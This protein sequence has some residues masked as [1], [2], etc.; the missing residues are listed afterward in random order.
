MA[1]I[2]RYLADKSALA[3]MSIPAVRSRLS[4]MIE[5]GLIATCAVIDLE[6]L[7]SARGADDYEAIL[8]ERRAFEDVP[9]TPSV[10]DRAMEV[11]RALAAEGRHRVP[12]PDLIIAAAAEST[13]LEVLHYDADYEEISRVT[14]QPQRWIVPRRSI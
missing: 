12:I 8:E 1:V 4:P 10:M 7:Y 3:R 14:G 13:D 5:H 2:A 9:I 11:Q 6:I